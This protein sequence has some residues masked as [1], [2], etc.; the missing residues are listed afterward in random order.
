MGKDLNAG[1]E[2][3]TRTPTPLRVHGPEPCASA[4]SATSASD[5]VAA[6]PHRAAFRK[7]Y[8]SI[9][10]G[11]LRLSNRSAPKFLRSH[12][13]QASTVITGSPGRQ[14]SHPKK[15]SGH[16]PRQDR[17]IASNDI[18]Q[19]FRAHMERSKKPA[20]DVNTRLRHLAHDLSNSLETILQACYLLAQTRL[21]SKGKKWQQA[22]ESAADDAARINRSI[23]EIL[24]GEQE[25][26]AIRRR[27]S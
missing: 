17:L 4:N 12:H 7:N 24:R 16:K 19:G 9:L 18:A 2:E 3:G 22:I 27:A 5:W 1:A 20:D 13:L 26:T 6:Q 10:Q 11:C 14:D 8:T 23:R 25:K 15:R 21:D